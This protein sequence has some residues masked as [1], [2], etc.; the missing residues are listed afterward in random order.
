MRT[1]ASTER[2]TS[3]SV[4][5]QFDTEMRASRMPCHVVA[6][7]PARAFTLHRVD[8]SVGLVGVAEP[9]EHL[10]EDDVVHDLEP[11]DRIELLREPASER[12]AAVDEV[13]HA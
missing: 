8:D 7:E 3:S 5:D 1:M 2:S 4:V 9:D 6:A 10:V 12:A 11:V 13:G